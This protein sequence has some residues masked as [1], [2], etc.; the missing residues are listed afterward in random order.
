MKYEG[1]FTPTEIDQGVAAA[2]HFLQQK[3]AGEKDVL[4]FRLTLEEVLLI[5]REHLGEGARFRLSVRQHFSE[6]RMKLA[7]RGERLDV[8][9]AGS[10]ILM[11]QIRSAGQVPRWEFSGGCNYITLSVPLYN[12][13][14][15]N[16]RFAWK[17]LVPHRKRF[18]FALGCQWVNIAL[19]IVLP[20]LSARLIVAFTD[21]A[22]EQVL[23]TA[24]MIFGVQILNNLSL[25][26]CN[27]QYNHVYT[28]VLSDLEGDLAKSALQI[29]NSCLEQKG[30]GLF[31][32]R[33]TVDTANLATGFNT[34][35]DNISTMFRYIGIL[36]A[37]LL[38]SPPVFL[39]AF[40]LLAAQ[41]VIEMIRTRRMTGDDR[42]YRQA[43]ERFSGFISEM[44]HGAPDIKVLNS[45]A[46][47]REELR[48]RIGH[49]NDSYMRM[50]VRS[51]KYKLAR[52][53][54]G[55]V[56]RTIYICTLGFLI[57]RQGMAPAIAIVLYNY[58]TE[59]GGAAVMLVGQTL[60]FAKSFNLSVERICAILNSPE[61][62][63]EEFGTVHLEKM[64]GEISF[65]HVSFRYE[66]ADFRRPSG[67]VIRDMSF[68][69]PAGSVVALVGKSGCGK[70]TVFRL[71]AKLLEATAGTVRLDGMDIRTLDRESIRENLTVVSQNPYL[72][73]MT[74]RENLRLVKQDLTEE[75]MKEVCR[76]ACIAEEIEQMPEGYD[77][78][79]GEGG[80]NLSGGQRQRLAIARSLL[81]DCRMLLFDEATSA[82]DNITQARVQKALEN[83]RGTRTIVMIAHRLSTV[84]NADRI[85]FMEDG[86]ILDQGTHQELIGRCEAYRALYEAESNLDRLFSKRDD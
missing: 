12:T 9:D 82:L 42:I 22:L 32:Q 39:V 17:Y 75:E 54:I 5:Y 72:F 21:S 3:G 23:L 43:N 41:I 8:W 13:P 30:G 77:S 10:E 1:Q 59:L 80:V 52:W 73:H 45:E 48:N 44:V 27:T 86:R 56:G 26:L 60:E 76:L 35:A 19:N 14:L 71:I 49:A 79:I 50:L 4:I 18:F 34:M 6:L 47:F 58:Y 57:A 40:L 53:E 24:A 36:I 33:L 69:I 67:M 20:V 29:R 66:S 70:S 2:V 64:R 81:R 28:R 85:Y 7:I 74:I 46:A 68:T 11:G 62:P 55:D 84:I 65:D 15:Q 63:K 78:L 61:F 37:L 25:F 16:M 38:V 31:I 83:I 51:W